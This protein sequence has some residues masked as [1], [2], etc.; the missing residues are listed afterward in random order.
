MSQMV[1]TYLLLPGLSWSDGV[2]VTAGDSV[3]SFELAQSF[4]AAVREEL[5]SR[6]LSYQALDSKTVEWRGVPGFR[7][8]TYMT[9]FFTPL[10]KHAW[11]DIPHSD[12]LTSPVSAQTPLGYGPYQIDE[13]VTG[14]SITLTK[15]PQYFRAAEGL[16]AIDE[17]VF[18]FIEPD[19]AA[20][21]EALL[22]SECDI[23]DESID[24]SAHIDR[25]MDL[26]AS[27]QIQ[28]AFTPGKAWEHLDFGIQ[29]ITYDEFYNVAQGDRPD[30][31]GDVRTRQ[32]IANCIDRGAIVS[33]LAYGQAA[34]M[35]TY[36]SASHPLF[37]PDVPLYPHD[38]AAGIALLEQVGWVMGEEGLRVSRGVA[39]IPDGVSFE[40][41][42]FTTASGL[43][44]EVGQIIGQNLLNCGIKI[45]IASGTPQELFAPGPDGLLF[46]RKFDLAQFGWPLEQTPSCFLF[47][48][49]AIPGGNIDQFTYSWGGWNLTG[50]KNPE[51]DAACAAARNALPGEGAYLSNHQIAQQI[52]ASELPVIPLFIPPKFVAARPDLC[53]LNLDPTA[54]VFWN[55]ESIDYGEFC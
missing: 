33:Q 10:P 14:Q 41:S 48:G 17:V 26:Q 8:P 43:H 34:V 29:P 27:G 25:L 3:Y 38:T 9:D 46:G 47:L 6:T 16:P 32:A 24:L 19:P 52:F 37:N 40:V 20:A 28:L 7:N 21:M 30:F 2:A 23:L 11:G 50:W 51:F 1:V 31:F 5:I 15:N 12:L 44:Q 49:E 42:Y 18:N 22:A 35:D 39:G 45:N 13:W 54:G 53:G 55:L 36:I 4:T